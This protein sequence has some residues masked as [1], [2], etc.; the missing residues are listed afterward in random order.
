MFIYICLFFYWL[1]IFLVAVYFLEFRS[2]GIGFCR[3]FLFR[4]FIWIRR[5]LWL[6]I[7][8]LFVYIFSLLR[9]SF[10]KEK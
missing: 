9:W 7:G 5:K 3:S 4:C 6:M 2:F 1:I 8:E 10:I